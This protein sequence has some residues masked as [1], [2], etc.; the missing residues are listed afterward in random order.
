MFALHAWVLHHV[1]AMGIQT[2]GIGFYRL[3]GTFGESMVYLV[4]VI[5]C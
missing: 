4:V 1:V 3:G 5:V 2:K